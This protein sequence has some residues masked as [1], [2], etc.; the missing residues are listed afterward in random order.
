MAAVGSG[1][2]AADRSATCGSGGVSDYALVVPP[3]QLQSAPAGAVR[4]SVCV[5]PGTASNGAAA[6]KWQGA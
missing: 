2:A 3:K 4:V 1:G 6:V 5:V